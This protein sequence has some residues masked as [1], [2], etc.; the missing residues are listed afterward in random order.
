M[1]ICD[2]SLCAATT[3]APTPP[4]TSSTPSPVSPIY[5]CL[6]LANFHP[7]LNGDWIKVAD[8]FNDQPYQKGAFYL[9]YTGTTDSNDYYWI[10]GSHGANWYY[11]RCNKA[12]ATTCSE[13]DWSHYGSSSGTV[14]P[15]ASPAENNIELRDVNILQPQHETNDDDDK[16]YSLNVTEMHIILVLLLVVLITMYGMGINKGLHQGRVF[17][18]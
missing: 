6:T 12:D 3:S 15:C 4:T 1:F 10:T 17:I 8:D 16:K 13:S 5:S 11:T 14:N 18:I 7:V 9:E 2:N